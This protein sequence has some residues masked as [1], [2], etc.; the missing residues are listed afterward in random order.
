MRAHL[1]QLDLAWEDRAAN[2][3]LVEQAADG[4]DIDQGDLIVLPELFD[5]GF[6]L[7]TDQTVDKRGETLSFLL[8]LAD[9]LGVIIHGSR[10]VRDCD[11][12]HATNHATVV[13]PGERVLCEYAKIHPFSFGR[14]GE[15]FVGGNDIRTYDWSGLKV[16]PAVCYDL[17]FPELFRFG[18]LAGAEAFVLGANWPDARQHHWRALAVARAIE[19]QA[20]VLAVNR[21][22]SDPHLHYVGGTIAVGPQ[23]DVLGELG[24]QP[25]VL[26]VDVDP[27]AVRNWRS[28]FRAA[29]DIRLIRPRP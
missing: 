22:G 24:H 5:S 11:C 17:R 12:T 25:G 7:N 9:D 15:A 26:S 27:D 1:F 14:E 8:E 4:I 2:C 19:N 6:S 20:Y 28:A 29:D 3:R 13:A 18:L 16:S 21:T 23:G 10:T